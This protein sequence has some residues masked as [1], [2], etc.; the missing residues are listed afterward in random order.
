M[1]RD[2]RGPP[3]EMHKVTCAECGHFTTRIADLMPE[4]YQKAHPAQGYWD[5]RYRRDEYAKFRFE[6]RPIVISFLEFVSEKPA[7]QLV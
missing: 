6:D 2:D 5:R 1:Y 7:K 4:H 3:R